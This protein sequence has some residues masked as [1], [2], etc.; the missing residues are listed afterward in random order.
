ML[1]D[2]AMPGESYFMR[3][4]GGPHDNVDVVV[5]ES[6][7]PWPL[8]GILGGE[9]GHYEKIS[10]SE[11]PPAVTGVIRSALYEWRREG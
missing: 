9:G 8:P 4:L 5:D 3:F 1:S 6:Q 7:F 10:E 2:G 11:L